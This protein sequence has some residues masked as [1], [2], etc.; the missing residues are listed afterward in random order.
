[1]KQFDI[2]RA[3]E[4]K[5][6]EIGGEISGAGCSLDPPFTMDFSFMLNGKKYAVT[7]VEKS[8]KDLKPKQESQDA[9]EKT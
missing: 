8:F 2:R 3:L 5:I 6:R 1:M 9:F 7:L 4:D